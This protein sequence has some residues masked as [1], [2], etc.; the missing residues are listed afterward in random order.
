VSRGVLTRA[1]DLQDIY[2]GHLKKKQKEMALEINSIRRNDI[3]DKYWSCDLCD[4][5]SNIGCR[6]FDPTECPKFR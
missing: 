1:T 2:E 3:Y 5:D 6:W 4:G